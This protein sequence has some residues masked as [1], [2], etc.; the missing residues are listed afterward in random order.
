VENI[1]S[2]EDKAARVAA[3]E[4]EAEWTGAGAPK[5]SSILP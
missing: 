1:G 4:T 3:A 2:A 5:S